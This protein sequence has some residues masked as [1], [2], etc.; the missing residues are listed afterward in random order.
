MKID[1]TQTTCPPL[2]LSLPD[3]KRLFDIGFSIVAL[4]FLLP[5]FLFISLLLFI[6][7]SGPLFFSSARA[8]KNG[9]P[10]V[11]WKFRTMYPDAAEMLPQLLENCE[12]SK[13]Q[14]E[15]YLKLKH[16]PRVTPIGKWLRKAS[17]DELPQLWNVLKGDLSIVGPRPYLLE[18]VET[19]LQGEAE[20]ILS[21]RPGITGIWQT[22]G[23]NRLPFSQRIALDAQYVDKRS[24]LF[25]LWLICKTI[26]TL[27]FMKGAY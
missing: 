14:W 2:S 8:G 18:E 27:L 10:F 4:V 1:Q 15:T 25:D 17:L 5:V 9:K 6:F 22:S 11:C 7:S 16:D 20:K 23:R 26:P 24:F 13:E 21:L 19:G 3:S 12:N